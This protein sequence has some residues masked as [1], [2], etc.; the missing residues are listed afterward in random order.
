MTRS[1]MNQSSNHILI[2]TNLMIIIKRNESRRHR[3]WKS[4]N[5]NKFLNNWREFVASSSFNCIAQVEAYVLKIQQCVL[6][7]IKIFVSWTNFFFEIKLF[8]NE[9]CVEAI[10]TTKR[11]RREWITLHIEKI[12]RNYLKESNEK[13]RIIAK[14]KKIEFKQVFRIICDSSSNLWRLTR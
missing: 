11:R 14:K 7:S 3:A 6:R 8:W 4:M 12:W 13:K 2:F 9:K 5:T 10:T 1:K